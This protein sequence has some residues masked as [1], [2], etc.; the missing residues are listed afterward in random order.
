MVIE[1]IPIPYGAPNLD[2]L[3]NPS[4][5]LGM[6]IWRTTRPSRALRTCFLSGLV[7]LDTIRQAG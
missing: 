3:P 7:V 6:A 5:C 1:G 2:L 4:C